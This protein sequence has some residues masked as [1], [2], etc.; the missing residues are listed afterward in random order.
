MSLIKVT[1]K[2]MYKKKKRKICG[3]INVTFKSRGEI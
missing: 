2:K 3:I 1:M